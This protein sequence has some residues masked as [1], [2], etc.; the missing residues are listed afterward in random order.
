ME[1]STK[2]LLCFPDVTTAREC[3]TRPDR[4]PT[5]AQPVVAPRQPDVR[6]MK[7]RSDKPEKTCIRVTYCQHKL[8]ALIDTG[9]DVSIAGQDV[10]RRMGWPIYA[11]HTREVSFANNKT[12]SILGA[13]RMV[14]F[15]A[16]HGVESEV[17][18]APDLDGLILG[19]DW[20]RSQ[21]RVKWD[22]DRGRI[23]FGKRDWV[24]LIQETGQPCRTSIIRKD[25]SI[26]DRGSCP[27]HRESDF[28]RP[29]FHA[30]PTGSARQF[31][32]S[33]S[34]RKFLR[35]VSLFRRAMLLVENE[36]ECGKASEP[37]VR[38]G[39]SDIRG[40]IRDDVLATLLLYPPRLSTLRLFE[41]LG[42]SFGACFISIQ[43]RV[44]RHRQKK[45][46]N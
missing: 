24:A 1:T 27:Y 29:A 28:D 15:V 2:L 3:P 11:H 17:L 22:F 41:V 10:A 6:P 44:K 45:T 5:L 36:R 40:R 7:R 8:S 14:L 42:G 33:R 32:C 39:V 12:M 26:T 18:I 35:E 25:S 13:T 46:P 43:V 23:K 34:N 21:G 31:C 20:L 30:A 19:I 38:R 9:S 16:R 4:P 37:G